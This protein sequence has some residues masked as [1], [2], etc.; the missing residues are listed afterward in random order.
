MRS[1]EDDLGALKAGMLA[2]FIVLNRKS[3]RNQR[4]DDSSSVTNDDSSGRAISVWES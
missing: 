4:K 1:R 3:I 2:D